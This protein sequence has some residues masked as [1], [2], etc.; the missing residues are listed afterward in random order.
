MNVWPLILSCLLPLCGAAQTLSSSAPPTTGDTQAKLQYVV[1]LSRHGVRSPTAAPEKYS[2]YAKGVWPKWPV[3]P[4]DLTPH[5]FQ[6]M[7]IFGAYDR[8]LLAQDGLLSAAGCG[9]TSHIRIYADSD[10][11]TIETGKAL[12]RGLM[13]G[14]ALAVESRPQGV[15]DPLF[16]PELSILHGSNPGNTATA[17]LLAKAAIAGR[18]GGDPANLALAYAQQLND[19]DHILAT[20]GDATTPGRKRIPLLDVPASLTTGTGDH[21]A[22]LKGPLSTASTL[23]EDLLLEYA[24]GMESAQVGWGCVHRSDLTWIMSLHTA[25]TDFTERTPV[26]ARLQAA[27]L[28]TAIGRSIEQETENRP[29]AGALGA[30][31]DRM[32]VLVGHDTNI[33][34]IAG[35]LRLSWIID[36]RRDDTPP[37]GALVFEVWRTPGAAT[38]FVRTYYTAQTLDQMRHATVLSVSQAPDRVPVFLPGCSHADGACPLPGFL[39]LL[40]ASAK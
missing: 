16:H 25:A 7:Q 28:L 5:G 8:M 14:C 34:N 19:L 29:V 13:H 32:L 37:G 3:P 6:L 36:G 2:A 24:E 21:L 20:C 11:R 18:L 12:A 33:E 22:D 15:R 23:A 1:V 9:D 27:P 40:R 17:S 4:G 39:D 30:P 26:I 31:S 10:E 38:P 35:A